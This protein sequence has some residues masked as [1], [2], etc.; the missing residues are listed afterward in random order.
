MKNKSF[1]LIHALLVLI[2]SGQIMAQEYRVGRLESALDL[3]RKGAFYSAEQMLNLVTPD[4]D[5]DISIFAIQVEAYKTMCAIRLDR[6]NIAGL[7]KNFE[8]RYPNAPEL[9]MVKF[10]LASRLFDREEYAAALVIYDSIK[11]P[12]S[13]QRSRLNMTSK[14]HTVI[15]GPAILTKLQRS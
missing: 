4:P 3:Y 6:S 10:A 11:S 13:M 5:S 7:V 1:I 15:S 14:A 9:Q 8:D 2:I 12:S